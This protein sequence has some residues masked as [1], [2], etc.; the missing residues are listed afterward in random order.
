M[1][2]ITIF[3]IGLLLISAFKAKSENKDLLRA[4]ATL[5]QIF[6]LYNAGHDHLLNE[7]YPYKPDNKATYLTGADTLSGRRV[8]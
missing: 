5:Q 6:R 4:K 3:T 8:A 7:T 1:K 2:S